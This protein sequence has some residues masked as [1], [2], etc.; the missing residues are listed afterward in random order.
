MPRWVAPNL[1]TFTGFL[2]TVRA[3]LPPLSWSSGA[4]RPPTTNALTRLVR[5]RADLERVPDQSL[6]LLLLRVQRRLPTVSAY[7]TLH[8]G[9]VRF[10]ALHGPHA[11]RHRRQA[12]TPH[13]FVRPAGRTVRPRR[14]QLD[15]HAGAVLH[16]LHFR[17]LRRIVRAAA[18]PLAIHLLD[19]IPD[20]LP[21]T[22]R[23]VQHG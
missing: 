15:G 23:K 14:R 19:R 3:T 4:P 2:F 13:R 17:P 16:L 11:R 10:R 12:G 6:R 7:S 18:L 22:R 8:L 9:C 20:V 5:F 1:L 21:V